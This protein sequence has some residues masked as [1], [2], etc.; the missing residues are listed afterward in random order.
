MRRP[1][2][3]DPSGRIDGAVV[4]A[5]VLNVSR[6]FNRAGRRQVFLRRLKPV[7]VADRPG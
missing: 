5:Y 1:A 2:G 4:R 7:V 3:A 6:R